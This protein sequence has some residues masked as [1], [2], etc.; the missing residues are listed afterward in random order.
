[1]N[2]KNIYLLWT[3]LL[4]ILAFFS[5]TNLSA[6]WEKEDIF[7]KAVNEE[8]QK[9]DK[10]VEEYLKWKKD[11]REECFW[12]NKQKTFS[13]CADEVEKKFDIAW[14]FAEKYY[15]A[16]QNALEKTVK[17][18]KNE[19]IWNKDS[20]T[21]L[22]PYIWWCRMLY[23]TKLWVYRD[24]NY[25]IFARNKTQ[26]L[27]DEMD[28]MARNQRKSVSKVAEQ[29]KEN[30]NYLKV[31]KNQFNPSFTPTWTIVNEG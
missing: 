7:Q 6:K 29:T 30:T 21:I 31:T 10:E 28:K 17:N 23:M 16:C 25:E 4:I 20:L 9:I 2:K 11:N 3:F 24:T 26:V 19:E 1:M 27:K 22:D 18:Q 15:E 13:K 14:D 12:P 5:Y 8:F